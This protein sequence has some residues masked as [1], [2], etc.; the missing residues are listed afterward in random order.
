MLAKK[1]K[2]ALRTL[3]DDEG[4]NE[5]IQDLIDTCIADLE[6][7][8]VKVEKKGQDVVDKNVELAIKY[9][10]RGHFGSSEENAKFLEIYDSIKAQ[11]GIWNG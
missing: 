11:L 6:R 2:V 5:E 9:Y 4:L 3:T 1:V 7:S 10:V 8:G